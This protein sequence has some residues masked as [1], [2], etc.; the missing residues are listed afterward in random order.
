[1]LVT[2]C[3]WIVSGTAGLAFPIDH[4]IVC[5]G[6][7][8]QCPQ[9]LWLHT[10]KAA[11]HINA[12]K[13]RRRRVHRWLLSLRLPMF[14]M[15]HVMLHAPSP[16][17]YKRLNTPVDIIHAKHSTAKFPPLPPPLHFQYGKQFLQ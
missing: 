1:V 8:K 6:T 15:L 2:V 9:Q 5:F 14:V 10:I 13:V 4:A 3:C 7:S 12:H 17:D 16:T 11:L